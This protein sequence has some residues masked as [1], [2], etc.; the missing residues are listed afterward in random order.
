MIKTHSVTSV[1]IAL[2]RLMELGN[3]VWIGADIWFV[4]IDGVKSGS[5]DRTYTNWQGGSPSIGELCTTLNEGEWVVTSCDT[6][7]KYICESQS[8][9]YVSGSFCTFLIARL[10]DYSMNVQ[11]MLVIKR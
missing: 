8:G 4:W 3:H 1:L 5:A 11:Q 6:N 10:S 7:N 9:C 2:F